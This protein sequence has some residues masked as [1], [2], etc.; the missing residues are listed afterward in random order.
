MLHFKSKKPKSMYTVADSRS[1]MHRYHYSLSV[2]PKTDYRPRLGD[3]RVGH[4]LT[5]HQDYT[6]LTRE[7]PY[8]R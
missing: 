7:T 2:I 8:V 5:M 3:D 1:F 6:S 4:F